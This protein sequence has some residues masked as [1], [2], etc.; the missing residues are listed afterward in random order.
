MSITASRVKKGGKRKGKR[1][2]K[3]KA[4]HEMTDILA[5]FAGG[6]GTSAA[7]E[8]AQRAPVAD[9]AVGGVPDARL[10]RPST[11]ARAAGRS[12]LSDVAGGGGGLSSASTPAVA[13]QPG[14]PRLLVRSTRAEQ[15]AAAA[16]RGDD[17]GAEESDEEDVDSEGCALDDSEEAD[18]DDDT[19]ATMTTIQTARPVRIRRGDDSESIATSILSSASS[20]RSVHSKRSLATVID[21][22]MTRERERIAAAV[23]SGA[24][25]DDA[26]P[27]PPLLRTAGVEPPRIVNAAEGAGAFAQKRALVSNLAYQRR[28]PAV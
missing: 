4:R 8:Y 18:T 9:V 13:T 20:I 14:G 15:A 2:G 11:T 25:D 6:A 27:V 21:R 1:K 12:V 7:D 10:A 24:T 23:A 19:L 5:S 22:H 26:V 16:T 3:K 28:H 17:S